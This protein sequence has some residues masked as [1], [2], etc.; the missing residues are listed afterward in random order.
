MTR[1]RTPRPLGIPTIIARGIVRAERER[2]AAEI[3]RPMRELFSVLES[4][5]VY[6]IGDRAVMRMPELDPSARQS[7]SD[8]V[9]IA[10]A[11]EGWIDCWQRIAPDLPHQ[12]MKYLADR[13]REDKA[14]TPRLVAKAREEFEG[15]ISMIPTLSNGQITDAVLRTQISWEFEKRKEA[16]A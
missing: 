12:H 7:P 10:P 1:K 5:E 3:A 6:V 16:A 11:L 8:W 15:T 14:L 4:G 13:L 2:R 9:E